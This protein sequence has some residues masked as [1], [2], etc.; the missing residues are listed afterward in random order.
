M[1]RP[2]TPPLAG[3]WW[4]ADGGCAWYWAKTT[5]SDG[6]RPE[7]NRLGGDRRDCW[8]DCATGKF[9]G[10]RACDG[11]RSGYQPVRRC[12]AQER[13][14][15]GKGLQTSCLLRRSILKP[16]LCSRITLQF[17][18]MQG[19]QGLHPLFFSITHQRGNNEHALTTS[20]C[21]VCNRLCCAS[22]CPRAKHRR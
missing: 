16:F 12:L 21:R 8:N 14:P 20:P 22:P 10:E 7:G 6:L 1:E 4:L 2:L 19:I 18:M 17:A 3:Y 5:V 15:S 11:G 9:Q 13:D